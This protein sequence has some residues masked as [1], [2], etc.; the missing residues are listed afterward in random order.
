MWQ[1]WVRAPGLGKA[2][3][4]YFFT[5]LKKKHL[6]SMAERFHSLQDTNEIGKERTV[7]NINPKGNVGNFAVLLVTEIDKSWKQGRRKVIDAEI[8][9]ILKGFEGVGFTRAGQ[10]TNN[11]EIQSGHGIAYCLG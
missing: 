6:N 9:G 3:G 5:S 10:P 2:P 1:K 8:S 11:D 4:Q 7:S